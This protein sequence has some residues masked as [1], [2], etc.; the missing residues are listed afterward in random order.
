MPKSKEELLQELQLI[1]QQKWESVLVSQKV[2]EAK[3]K[4]IIEEDDDEK[5]EEKQINQNTPPTACSI[6]VNQDQ[7]EQKNNKMFLLQPS[8]QP[9]DIKKEFLDWYRAKN[10]IS[11]EVSDKDLLAQM[12]KQGY[13]ITNQVLANGTHVISTYFPH[14]KDANEFTNRLLNKGI[15]RAASSQEQQNFLNQK[16][17]ANHPDAAKQ[18]P[19]ADETPANSSSAKTP[20]PF[21]MV[22]RPPGMS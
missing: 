2:P 18:S 19:K 4:S 20:K 14:E 9:K 22:P 3:A 1:E 15:V 11:K 10:H 8:F 16:D 12:E 7:K 5:K 21:S 17:H 6:V 13:K